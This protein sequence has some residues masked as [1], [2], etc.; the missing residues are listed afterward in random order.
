MS[1]QSSNSRRLIQ[2]LDDSSSGEEDEGGTHPNN[3]GL[4]VSAG[5]TSSSR[6]SSSSGDED[7]EILSIAEAFESKL[8][9]GTVNKSSTR[10]T[11]WRRNEAKNTYSVGPVEINADLYDKLFDYQRDGVAWMANLDKGGVLGD[12]MGLGKTFQALAYV[13]GRLRTGSARACVVVAPKSVAES[14]YRTAQQIVTTAGCVVCLHDSTEKVQKGHRAVQRMLDQ[15]DAKVLI[16]TTYPVVKSTTKL[17]ANYQWDVVVL[18]EAH[19]IKSSK[20]QVSMAC[21]RMIKHDPFRIVLTGTP[22]LNQLDELWN[23]FEFATGKMGNKKRFREQYAKPIEKS[24]ESTA[25]REEVEKGDLKASQ[26]KSMLEP[27]L[28]QRKKEEVLQHVLPEKQEYVIW[29]NLTQYQR[30]LYQNYVQGGEARRIVLAGEYQGA[31]PGIAFLKNIC[32]HPSI[33]EKHEIHRQASDPIHASA[34]LQTISALVLHFK[35]QGHRTLVFSQSVQMLNIIQDVLE[36]ENV[37]ILRLDG[38]TKNRQSVVDKFNNK[39]CPVDAMLLSTKAGGVGLTLTA[40]TRVIIS[41]PSWTPAEDSQA[42]DRCYRIGQTQKVIAYRIITAGTVEEKVYER[43]VFKEGLKRT[44]FRHETVD[45]HFSKA[46]L[47]KVFT[48]APEGVCEMAARIESEALAIGLKTDWT[49]QDFIID[50]PGVLGYSRHDVLYRQAKPVRNS[51]GFIKDV[52]TSATHSVPSFSKKGRTSRVL[53]QTE[54]TI[55]PVNNRSPEKSRAL[56]NAQIAAVQDQISKGHL[57]SALYLLNNL[58]TD[59][60]DDLLPEERSLAL[61]LTEKIAEELELH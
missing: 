60:W 22:L 55:M 40:A 43:Q 2:I 32:N 11:T 48:L 54:N 47:A 34:K 5:T 9:V 38:K 23:I 12:D 24:R 20:T 13:E 49:E 6:S 53:G 27:F 50:L 31:L 15:R 35:K 10:S 52:A 45:R 39:T 56:C 28:L 30:R 58:R 33:A 51:G 14:W 1:S 17:L 21:Y 41:D 7:E 57:K 61:D 8:C 25:S 26:L 4:V 29:T 19:T 42:I 18:D 46:D 3:D 37:Q 59:S 44:V 36:R 16:I